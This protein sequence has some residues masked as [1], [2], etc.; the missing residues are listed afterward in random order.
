MSSG[1]QDEVF[2]PHGTQLGKKIKGDALFG[3]D[4]S[5]LS[6]LEEQDLQVHNE[7]DE[8]DAAGLVSGRTVNEELQDSEV[9]YESEDLEGSGR[10]KKRYSTFP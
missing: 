1:R 2:A 7:G 9:D 10:R 3:D 5:D 6:D 8:E 4:E